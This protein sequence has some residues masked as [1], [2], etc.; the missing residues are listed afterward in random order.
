M[1]LLGAALQLS[2]SGQ[3]GQRAARS[4]TVMGKSG[5]IEPQIVN[6]RIIHTC[7]TLFGAKMN[8]KQQAC[9]HK[10]DLSL[11]NFVKQL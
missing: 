9:K 2:S 4:V 5:E 10:Q 11:I 3:E 6:H 8:Q 1:G 7:T